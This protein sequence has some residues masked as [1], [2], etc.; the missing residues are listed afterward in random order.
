MV[1]L[2]KAEE[3]G[4]SFSYGKAAGK[5]KKRQIRNKYMHQQSTDFFHLT[6]RNPLA[7]ALF[8]GKARMEPGPFQPSTSY[9]VI[10][11]VVLFYF[12]A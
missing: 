12:S 10:L 11:M 4:I 3:N 6:S 8:E 1:S 2:Q 5:S 7:R 9:P